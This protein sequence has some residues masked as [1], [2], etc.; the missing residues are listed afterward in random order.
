[1]GS[2]SAGPIYQLNMRSVVM[3]IKC[4][5]TKILEI[6]ENPTVSQLPSSV[7]LSNTGEIKKLAGIC[8]SKAFTFNLIIFGMLLANKLWRI[9][10]NSLVPKQT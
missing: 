7:C 4:Q 6:P 9:P 3:G 10:T 5:N 8:I 2:L 1:M